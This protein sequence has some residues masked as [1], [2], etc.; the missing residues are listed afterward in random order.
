MSMLS[1]DVLSAS[2]ELA[3]AGSVNEAMAT[4]LALKQKLV[5]RLAMR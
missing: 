1:P 5:A 2:R 4:T 3:R